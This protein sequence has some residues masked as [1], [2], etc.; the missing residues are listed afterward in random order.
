MTS[1]ATDSNRSEVPA[2]MPRG[3]VVMIGYFVILA[4]LV[5]TVPLKLLGQIGPDLGATGGLL[6]WV[7]IIGTLGGAIG[8]ALLPPMAKLFG[9]RV[10][11]LT[12]MG[13]LA[14]GCFLA[15]VAPNMTVLLIGRFIG[16]FTLG[17]IALA[18]FMA[19]SNLSGRSLTV[20]LAWIAAAEGV[21]AGVSFAVGGLLADT[22][23]VNWR[24]ILGVIA[25]LGVIGVIG[26]FI[27]IP[28]HEGLADA[29]V[30]WIGGILLTVA[31]ALILVPLSM[32]SKWGWSSPKTLLPLI[33]GV[34][35]AV[36]WWLVEERVAQPL[37]NTRAL[38]NLNFLRGW[39]V[40]FLAGMSTWVIN[41]TIPAFTEVPPSAGFGFGYDGL[42][43]GLVMLV[44]C[45]G[46]VVGSAVT[47]RLSRLVPART[48]SMVAFGGFALG[49]LLMA[50]AHSAEWQLWAW[51][52]IVGLSYGMAVAS[53]YMTFIKALHPD[54]VS[55]AAGMG[56]IAGPLGSSIG[57]AAI[58]G[59]LTAS[60]IKVGH[61]TVP[62]EHSF[63]LGWF[64]GVGIAVVGFLLVA[65]VRSTN[66]PADET[67]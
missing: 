41:F 54:Q 6:N 27:G 5:T 52:I 43:S 57:S 56:Q 18:L 42:R 28:K 67:A 29:K 45:I 3:L 59:I 24:I 39:V 40:F 66:V 15:A 16:G 11:A 14:F 61:H 7:V 21:A 12:T 1:T 26:T 10:V 23:D 9:Q 50:V 38:R 33:L 58:T 60:V 62:S 2:A 44:Y 51:P 32:G 55:T 46:I 47:D 31:L 20:V 30:D 48:V 64:I 36:V 63:Q 13:L 34:V 53:A 49:M 35:V 37:V 25:A 4:T 19:R 17:A 65:F 22:V 8:T